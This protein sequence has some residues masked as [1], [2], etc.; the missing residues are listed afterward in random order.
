MKARARSIERLLATARSKLTN[1]YYEDN[2]LVCR[3]GY[4]SASTF[5]LVSADWCEIGLKFFSNRSNALIDSNLRGLKIL[6]S[7]VQISVL[8]Y[9]QVT[10]TLYWSIK[11]ETIRVY[12]SI[13]G[14]FPDAK[15]DTQR[16]TSSYSL[17]CVTLR[18]NTPYDGILTNQIWL[19]NPN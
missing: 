18:D 3:L 16:R 1:N 5:V 19:L 14:S 13:F 15:K 17:R 11:P 12:L 7:G 4:F 8:A 2:I 6:L 10:S 9:S